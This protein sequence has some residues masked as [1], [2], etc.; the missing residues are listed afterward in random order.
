MY[1]DPDDWRWKD[2]K[3][4]IVLQIKNQH[5]SNTIKSA[6]SVKCHDRMLFAKEH[7]LVYLQLKYHH[8]HKLLEGH[9]KQHEV[10]RIPPQYRQIRA[11]LQRFHQ[12]RKSGWNHFS[13][14]FPFHLLFSYLR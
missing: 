7:H 2:E 12:K 4:H 13:L 8:P 14:I 1:F 9:E 6:H 10:L 3:W 11:F 5:E